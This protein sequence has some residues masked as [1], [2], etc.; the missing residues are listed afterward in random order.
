MRI[1]L[2]L[3]YKYRSSTRHWLFKYFPDLK[4]TILDFE[5]PP[6]P[7]RWSIALLR[8]TITAL[9]IY[10]RYDVVF[11]HGL[12]S[13]LPLAFVHS[14]L[15]RNKP[16]FVGVDIAANRG[17]LFSPLLR[18]AV[19]SLDAIVC[20]TT[21]QR[22][23][24]NKTVSYKA[25]F[26]HLGWDDSALQSVIGRKPRPK[27]YIFSGGMI[28]RDYRTLFQ[29]TSGLHQRMLIVA[30]RD[31]VAGKT[32][33]EQTTVPNDAEIY[34]EVPYLRFLELMASAKMIAII[35]KDVPYAAGQ[36]VLL[37]AMAMGKPIVV[38]RTSG[39]VDYVED[40]K[41]A[42]LVEPGNS[43]D[44]R[45]KIRQILNDSELRN[46]LAKNAR[47]KWKKRFTP[48]VMCAKIAEII[49]QVR[50]SSVGNNAS[51]Y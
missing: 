44:L 27:S 11:S 22:N 45:E 7:L 39:T 26:V 43:S 42:L 14:L 35:L 48:E 37:E 28:A 4:L 12:S 21:A 5:Q 29:A 17:I 50:G 34:F 38:T 19:K 16:K 49:R 20:F 36:S 30:G 6:T 31:P 51:I 23:W 32:G 3:A 8:Q 9:S 24:W 40:E 41:T 47:A 2:L 1:L 33:L 46:S 10:R 15:H 25:K 13:I 18:I